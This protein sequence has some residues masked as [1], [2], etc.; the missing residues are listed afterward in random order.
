[1][2]DAHLI[3]A[4]IFGV[5][6][7]M[8]S[9]NDALEELAS[10][11]HAVY[12]NQGVSAATAAFLN[13]NNS[14][15]SASDPKLR[16]ALNGFTW[17]FPDGIGIR[18]VASLRGIW[19]GDNIPG[20]DL[21]PSLLRH[22]GVAGAR[23]FMLGHTAGGLDKAARNFSVLFP[24]VTLVG[25]YHGYF[26][27]R[28]DADVLLKINESEA[29]ILLVGMGTPRQEKWLIQHASMLRPRLRIAVGGLFQY[30]SVEL[31]RAPV[32][33]R[34]AWLEWFWIMSHQPFK[35]RRYLLGGPRFFFRLMKLL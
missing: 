24:A 4:S 3:I 1:M 6:L 34:R 23:V 17:V 32:W 35:W 9:F 30:W 15:I 22:P 8:S 2:N 7:N 28:E 5:K 21:V 33:V 25:Y 20:S 16:D 26:D 27:A 31:R 14:N 13:A 29:D 12:D 11:W 19:R 18:L 10:A